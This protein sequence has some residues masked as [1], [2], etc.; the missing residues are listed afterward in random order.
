MKDEAQPLSDDRRRKVWINRT[1]GELDDLVR[2]CDRE[3]RLEDW[4]HAQATEQNVLIY[5]AAKAAETRGEERLALMAEWATAFRTGPGVIVLRGAIPNAAV[6]DRATEVFSAIIAEEKDASAR[7]DYFITAGSNDRVWNSLQKHCLADPKNFADYFSYSAIDMACRAWLGPGYQMT[8]QCFRVNPGGKAQDA[9][10]DYHLGF[11]TPER[12][13]A[14][15]AHV[16]ELSPMLT[17]QGG[18]AHIDMPLETG[19]TL[20]LPYSQMYFEGYLAFE[21]PEFQDYFQSARSQLPMNKGDAIFFNPAVMHCAG[22]N[23]TE[24]RFRLVNLLQVSSAMGRPMEAID[25][26]RMITALFPVL[27]GGGWSE[28]ALERIIS[29]SAEGYAF[30]TNLDTDPAVGGMSPRT[31]ADLMRDALA[32]G[33][34]PA[35]FTALID[36]LDARRRG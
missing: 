36:T 30:P 28:D 19:P 9:H 15:P 16:Q 26:T 21:R 34:T 18:V 29:A 32:D 5:D 10:R 31:H 4:P 8:A 7:G 23:V 2:L 17:L 13:E 1:D 22:A 35:A 14:Y 25:R 20:Y 6:M 33:T 24:D 3:T 12:Q 27:S 11:M